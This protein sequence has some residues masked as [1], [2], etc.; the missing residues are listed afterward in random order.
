[1]DIN[2]K[3]NAEEV[4]NI[5]DLVTINLYEIRGDITIISN[6][7]CIWQQLLMD[8]ISNDNINIIKNRYNQVMT[9]IHL[10]AYLL[11]PKYLRNNFFLI[12]KIYMN[13]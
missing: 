11:S 7:T 2:L 10:L 9:T 12:R 13:I 3:N 4:Y 5:M 8:S 1:M 6:E